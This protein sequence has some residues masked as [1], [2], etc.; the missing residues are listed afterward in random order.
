MKLPIHRILLLA[1]FLF[2]AFGLKAQIVINEVDYDQPGTDSSEFVELYNVS[3]GSIDLSDYTLILFNGSS[4]S[5]SPYDSITL[6]A[7]MLPPGGF[8]VICGSSTGLVSPCDTFLATSVG[9]GHI[10]N[11]APDGMG[12]RYNPTMTIVDALSYE[13]DCPAPYVEGTGVPDSLSDNGTTVGVGLSRYPDGNDTQ[14]NAADFFLVCSTPGAPNCSPVGT[15]D[16]NRSR[17]AVSIYPNP[18]RQV[19]TVEV[20]A[21]RN[22]SVS[23]RN[24]LGKELKRATSS[25]DRVLVDLSGIDE[26]VYLLFIHSDNGDRT[27]RLVVHH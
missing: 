3:L 27:E 6:P 9:T 1:A 19:V 21:S 15:I 10:Q 2:A 5:L 24:I 23:V 18:A 13:G 22:I 4:A 11:G 7:V 14:N 25:R 12:L 26:G 17:K 8:F 20:P 16:R